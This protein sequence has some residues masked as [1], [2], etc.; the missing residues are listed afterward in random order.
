[1][2]RIRVLCA[3]TTSCIAVSACGTYV[4][5]KTLLQ[6]DKLG[7]DGLTADGI[8]SREGVLEEHIVANIRCDIQNAIFKTT[9]ISKVEYLNESWGTQVTLKLTWDESS[10]LGPSVSFITPMSAMQ[11]RSISLGASATAH[12]TRV[13]TITFL[14]KN[15]D[16]LKSYQMDLANNQNTVPDCRKLT[17]GLVIDSDLKIGDFIVDKATLA[18]TGEA[19]T[20]DP[21]SPPFTTFQEDLTFVGSFGGNITPTW[22]LTHLAANSS[23]N[24]LS[25]TRT[26]T[27]DVLITLGPLVPDQTHPGRYLHQL[28]DAAAA[29]HVA[30]ITGGAVASQVNS[31]SH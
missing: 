13:E 31:Q 9:K 21:D 12:A 19:S 26:M 7:S 17:T 22:K 27:G 14:Y 16:L 10:G 11:S 5:Q 20:D 23:G 30:G 15:S 24:L 1:M 2:A 28:G 4:P 25:G 3:V 18:S 8:R 6:A 29:Q